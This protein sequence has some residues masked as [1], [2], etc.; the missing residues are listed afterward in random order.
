MKT[1]FKIFASSR[2][3]AASLFGVLLVLLSTSTASAATFKVV[4]NDATDLDSVSKKDLVNIFMKKTK[5]WDS[6][7]AIEV[8]DLPPEDSTRQDFSVEVLGFQVE[9]V[10]AYWQKLIFS[11]RATPPIVL[12]NSE[13]VLKFVASNEGAIGYVAEGQD[14]PKGVKV[15]TIVD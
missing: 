7:T 9:R 14:V 2:I 1:S 5:R 3:F 6:G 12:A 15:L 11:G 10:K 8:V 13:E 4:T